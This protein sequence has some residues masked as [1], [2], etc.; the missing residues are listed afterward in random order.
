MVWS[1]GKGFF[2]NQ[3]DILLPCCLFWCHFTPL[4]RAKCVHRRKNPSERDR[5]RGLFVWYS[6]CISRLRERTLFYLAVIFFWFLHFLLLL[7]DEQTSPFFSEFSGVWKG[8]REAPH[9]Q[10]IHILGIGFFQVANKKWFSI[11]SY[12][13]RGWGCNVRHAFIIK[14]FFC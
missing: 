5:G 6:V 13:G 9:A 2:W 8:L 1:Q 12:K 11:N 4:F 14:D 7:R 3:G 10:C